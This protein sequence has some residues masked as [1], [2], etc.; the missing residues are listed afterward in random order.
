V[1]IRRLRKKLGPEGARIVTVRTVGYRMDISPSWA[2]RR[3][4]PHANPC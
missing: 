2:T 1:H 3:F 4:G